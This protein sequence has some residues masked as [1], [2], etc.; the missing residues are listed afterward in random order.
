MTTLVST[1]VSN[2]YAVPQTINARGSTDSNMGTIKGFV[3]T[4][5]GDQD[6][7]DI[8]HLCVL[9]W[10]AKI[11]SIV[12]YNDDLDVNATPTFAVDV[13]IYKMNAAGTKT[14]VD[15]DAYASAIT[16]LQAANTVGVNVAFEARDIIKIGQTVIE[17]AGLTAAPSDGQVA[18][19]SMTVT[20]VSA[21]PTAG[22]IAF[23]VTYTQ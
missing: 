1:P 18:L 6:S 21:T 2:V 20:T 15:V 12:I 5:T 8:I 23:T 13:G 14:A 11:H 4:A 16:T 17:D 10:N 7:A 3:T 9:P 19:L 22:D